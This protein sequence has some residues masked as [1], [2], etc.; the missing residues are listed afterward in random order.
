MSSYLRTG[1]RLGAVAVATHTHTHTHTRVSTRTMMRLVACVPRVSYLTHAGNTRSS[2]RPDRPCAISAQLTTRPRSN[3]ATTF[4]TSTLHAML[5]L[6]GEE[7]FEFESDERVYASD[8]DEQAANARKREGEGEGE[9]CRCAY[10][11]LSDE[12]EDGTDAFSSASMDVWYSFTRAMA[13]L[14][15]LGSR[16]NCVHAARMSNSLSVDLLPC[17]M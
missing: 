4:F 5:L 12:G 9:G 8:K 3:V 17:F 7:G 10:S 13:N 16:R 6:W 15:A 2:K 14:S 1:L 11:S